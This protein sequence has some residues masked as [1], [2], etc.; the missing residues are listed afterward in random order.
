MDELTATISSDGLPLL[1]VVPSQI[2]QL[3]QNLVSN[4]LKFVSVDKYRS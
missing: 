3:F 4:S 1:R 2:R